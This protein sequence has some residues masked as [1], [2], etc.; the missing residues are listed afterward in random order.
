MPGADN[1]DLNVTRG[2]EPPTPTLPT[3]PSTAHIRPRE[4]YDQKKWDVGLGRAALQKESALGLKGS[5]PEHALLV[6]SVHQVRPGSSLGRRDVL[7]VL[8]PLVTARGVK[9][10]VTASTLASPQLP[11]EDAE[12]HFFGGERAPLTTPPLCKGEHG[13]QGYVTT[14]SI[15]P[16]SAE[17]EGEVSH[18]SSEFDLTEGPN[19]SLGSAGLPNRTPPPTTAPV[20]AVKS[21]AQAPGLSARWRDLV[22][23]TAYLG[24]LNTLV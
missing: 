4:A 1:G 19:L 22:P 15:V 10:A 3:P 17:G 11:F 7:T 12:F 2:P 14:T 8:G 24:A 23:L 9:R 13:E 21:R 6:P 20:W 5:L 16:W 18:P